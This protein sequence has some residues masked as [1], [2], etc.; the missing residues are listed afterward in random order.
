[1]TNAW[2][3][4]ST[5]HCSVLPLSPCG[6]IG[7]TPPLSRSPWGPAPFINEPEFDRPGRP[8][9][10]GYEIFDGIAEL[11]P[12]LML[13]ARATTFI[14]ER[15]TSIRARACN[16]ATATCAALPELQRLYSGSCPHYAMWDDHDYGPDNSDASWIHKDWAAQT[17][18]EFWANPSQ[19]L[20]ALQNQGSPL[21]S[22]FTT[23]TFF[24]STT[25]LSGST[26]TMLPN[27]PK[28]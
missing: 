19:G 27:N 1:M 16:T 6:S 24:S 23:S 4:E 22:N 10:G 17:F 13:V 21:R 7:L 3:R 28:S 2:C 20:P 18:G 9:G 26:M 8:Y 14:S 25:V 12:D 15:W 5:P 11:E